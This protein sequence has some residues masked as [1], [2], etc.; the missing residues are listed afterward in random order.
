M[1]FEDLWIRVRITTTYKNGTRVVKHFMS[2]SPNLRA[3]LCTHLGAD[4]EELDHTIDRQLEGWH[5][6]GH[7]IIYDSPT[8]GK[9]YCYTQVKKVGKGS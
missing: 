8:S 5:Q 6:E 9:R 3:A 2:S 7:K 4:R 1:S